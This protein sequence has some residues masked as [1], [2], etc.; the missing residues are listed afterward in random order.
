MRR[1]AILIS[2][3]G[4]NMHALA[5]AC[6]APGFPARPVVILSDRADAP[7][8]QYA[9]CAGLDCAVVERSDYADR[10]SFDAAL[11]AAI[12]ARG[13]DLV[14]LAG[15]MRVLGAAFVNRW[16]WRLINI[17]PSLLPAFKGL[18]THARVLAAGERMTGCTVHFV[19]PVLDD[20][21]II[22]QA[23]V[24]VQP[25]DTPES[26]AARVLV[27]EHRIYPL[28]VRWIVEDRVRVTPSGRV[29]ISGAPPPEIRAQ[30]G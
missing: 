8:L 10:E 19:T 22:L 15:F 24:P 3:R 9:R 25:D 26:L 17:H 18:D 27:Q 16:R 14:C 12:A 20:G 1:L 28:A 23:Q 7:G 30:G 11:D 2:G 6:R 29:L 13:A 5:A 4:S 21:P